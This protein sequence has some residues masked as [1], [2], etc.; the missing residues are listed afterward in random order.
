MIRFAVAVF[1]VLTLPRLWTFGMFLDGLLYASIARNMADGAGTFNAPYYSDFLGKVFLWHPPLSMWLHS[2][3]YRALGDYALVDSLFGF[4]SGCVILILL[5]LILRT[6]DAQKS[7]NGKSYWS[8]VLL[9]SL[10]P[11]TS[12]IFSNNML[13]ITMTVFILASVYFQLRVLNFKPGA[14]TG[15]TLP[16]GTATAT[17]QPTLCRLSVGYFFSGGFLALAVL[18]KNVA[19]LFPLII[20]LLHYIL[21]KKISLKKA[22]FLSFLLTAAVVFCTYSVLYFSNSVEFYKSYLNSQLFPSLSGKLEGESTDFTR[23]IWLM[24]SEALIPVLLSVF[25]TTIFKKWSETKVSRLSLFFLI[26]GLS[27]TL[28]LFLIH[29]FRSYYLYPGLPFFALSIAVFF[30]PAF[31]ELDK[32]FETSPRFRRYTNLFSSAL[33]MAS[34]VLFIAGKNYPVRLK[35]F[36][37]DVFDIP[38]KIPARST[39]TNCMGYDDY[40][41]IAAFQRYFKLSLINK[42]NLEN[43]RWILEDK[44]NKCNFPKDCKKINRENSVRY[45]IYDCGQDSRS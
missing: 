18:S 9:V 44:N 35:E 7:E 45:N 29:K 13:E 21:F 36:K 39:I 2:L 26:L 10:M 27:G 40:T 24:V 30:A 4:L 31:S 23:N 25:I 34:V 19:G 16:V 33:I 28:P 15:A 1:F 38:L 6:V 41:L 12:W 14:M 3:F 43:S 20:P 8:V 42:S 37:H 22:V 17:F 5:Y 11:M 32:K